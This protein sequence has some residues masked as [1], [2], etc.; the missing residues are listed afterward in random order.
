MF[1]EIKLKDK[2][3]LF[4]IRRTENGPTFLSLV[5]LDAALVCFLNDTNLLNRVLLF[6]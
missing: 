4:L 1:K 3:T 6:V 5:S 2:L